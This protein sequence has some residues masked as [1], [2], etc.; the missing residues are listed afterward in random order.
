MNLG[1]DED[2]NVAEYYGIWPQIIGLVIAAA[3]ILFMF[4]YADGFA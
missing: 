2:G 4:A 1:E 3:L